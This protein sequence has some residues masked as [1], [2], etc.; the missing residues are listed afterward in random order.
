MNRWLWLTGLLAVAIW[1]WLQPPSPPPPAISGDKPLAT[2]TTRAPA[3]SAESD[4]ATAPAADSNKAA[5]LT[6]QCDR[7]ELDRP[8]WQQR[9]HQLLVSIHQLLDPNRPLDWRL[10]VMLYPS[11]LLEQQDLLF[12]VLAAERSRL[13][14]LQS[15]AAMRRQLELLDWLGALRKDSN[16][17]PAGYGS[18]GAFLDTPLQQG[19]SVKHLL[20][21]HADALP[22]SLLTRLMAEVAWEASDSQRLPLEMAYGWPASH[23]QALFAAIP[24]LGHHLADQLLLADGFQRLLLSPAGISDWAPVLGQWPLDQPPSW[25]WPLPSAVDL[26]LLADQASSAQLH[27]WQQQGIANS[28]SPNEPGLLQLP[29]WLPGAP[30]PELLA[31][32]TLPPGLERRLPPADYQ[33]EELQLASLLRQQLQPITTEV[34]QL[35]ELLAVSEQQCQPRRQQLEQQQRQW[36]WSLRSQGFAPLEE[37]GLDCMDPNQLDAIADIDPAA[38]ETCAALQRPRANQSLASGQPLASWLQLLE[39]AGLDGE[40]QPLLRHVTQDQDVSLL[41]QLVS[42]YSPQLLAPLQA[43]GLTPTST[44]LQWLDGEGARNLLAAGVD[45][46][47][48]KGEHSVLQLL[49]INDSLDLPTLEALTAAGISEQASPLRRDA[50]DMLL[51]RLILMPERERLAVVAALRPLVEVRPSHWRRLAILRERNQVLFEELTA[52]LPELIPP[53]DMAPLLVE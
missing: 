31:A 33:P 24:E 4:L 19:L 27:S 49:A 1:W 45:L 30:R 46:N 7:H 50:M 12:L 25:R 15:I 47:R 5:T 37:Q 42:R 32:S 51:E 43:T 35:G 29:L 38:A 52:E 53:A 6:R 36:Y 13:Y 14:P 17:I 10:L 34:N 3:R 39:Q 9:Q 44:Q 23:W 26:A 28:L 16:A 11:P 22:T 20:L 21:R 40:I 2:S 48:I 8:R 41:L 18:I